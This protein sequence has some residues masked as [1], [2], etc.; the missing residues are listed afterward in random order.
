MCVKRVGTAARCSTPSHRQSALEQHHGSS[1]DDEITARAHC[2]GT[3]EG[4]FTASNAPARGMIPGWRATATQGAFVPARLIDCRLSHKISHVSPETRKATKPNRRHTCPV[5]APVPPGRARRLSC[6]KRATR[7]AGTPGEGQGATCNRYKVPLLL[8]QVLAMN[9]PD[10]ACRRL[11]HVMRDARPADRTNA[12]YLRVDICERLA[13]HEAARVESSKAAM[14]CRRLGPD[15]GDDRI[16][17]RL[18][19]RLLPGAPNRC[20]IFSRVQFLL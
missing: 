3:R 1:S 16:H 4:A 19:Y 6:G 13:A 7:Y 8:F 20:H 9:A 18:A 15:R 5:S 11:E 12:P 2:A 10:L 17:P 14:S